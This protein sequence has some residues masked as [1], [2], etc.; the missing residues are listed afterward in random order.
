MSWI[1]KLEQGI[2]LLI[3]IAVFLICSTSVYALFE[4]IF[5][6]SVIALTLTISSA[7][8]FLFALIKSHHE[9]L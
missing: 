9:S 8:G 7:I 4:C 2:L 1:D 6:D 5:K 3:I